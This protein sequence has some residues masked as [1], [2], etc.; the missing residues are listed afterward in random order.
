MTDNA[1]PQYTSDQVK[2]L[3]DLQ[4][5]RKKPNGF[6]RGRGIEGQFHMLRE[7]LDNGIDELTLKSTNAFLKIMLLR[8]LKK[9]KYQLI[10]SDTGRG[11]PTEK[12]KA[13]TTVIGTSAKHD[14]G[15]VYIST[16]GQFGIGLKVPAALSTRYRILSSNVS[17]DELGSITIKNGIV[18]SHVNVPGSYPHGLT[19]VF[20]PDPIFFES[21]KEFM[22][23]EYMVIVDFIRKI[24]IFN[25]KK[26]NH[27]T[28]HHHNNQQLQRECDPSSALQVIHD[29]LNN[30]S[31][32]IQ[33]FSD[34]YPD[35]N[36]YLFD[37]WKVTSPI[38][39]RLEESK[40]PKTEKDLLGFQVRC[41]FTSKPSSSVISGQYYVSV[42]NVCLP[43]TTRNSASIVFTSVLKN[44]LSPF[45]KE[46]EY[47]PFFMENYRLPSMLVAIDI[48]YNGAELIG[49]TKESFRDNTFSGQFTEELESILSRHP[50]DFW[51]TLMGFL[52]Q[53]IEESYLRFY[54]KPIKNTDNRKTLI[55]LNFPKYYKGAKKFG[56]DSELFI[57]EGG[58]AGGGIHQKR[59]DDFQAVL[60]TLGKPTN[61]ANA[62]TTGNLTAARE[63]LMKDKGYQDAM[64]ILNIYPNTTDMSKANF[65]KI[66]V[67]T[68][69]DPDGKHIS[70]CH[71]I[72]YYILNPR[73][74]ESGMLYLADPPL[75]SMTIGRSGNIFLRDEESFILRK[76]GIYR[77]LLNIKVRTANNVLVDTANDEK[78]FDETCRVILKVGEIYTQL[79]EQMKIPPL[80][81]EKITQYLDCMIP[82]F[83]PFD[84]CDRFNRDTASTDTY[85]NMQYDDIVQAII[86]SIGDVDH[87]IGIHD[88]ALNIRL[89][90]LPIIKEFRAD[91]LLFS[92]ETKQ[93]GSVY[94]RKPRVMSLVGAYMH[95]KTCDGVF[96]VTR[97]KGLGEM[98]TSD[99]FDAI[100]N[101]ATRSIIP[102]T[103]IGSIQ[104]M[105]DVMGPDS[106][107]RKKLLLDNGALSSM[108]RR[109]IMKSR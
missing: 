99:L 43:D 40:T 38:V 35:K 98:D 51:V 27:K 21:V 97:H 80:I 26:T 66:I 74:I 47:V 107:E 9:K 10:V 62:I 82:E 105:I 30:S 70:A 15:G 58:S 31:R 17:K 19:V 5:I 56:P 64:R 75:Y 36:A 95:L 65:G 8:D 1:L 42:N 46:K 54:N 23:S 102:I 28:N 87:A 84:L 6:I 4:L 73:I 29:T 63:L 109:N 91:E 13:A 12:L 61:A 24:N 89:R 78:L 85:I 96:T 67:S 94:Y 45:V 50:E 49:I 59:F 7:V 104:R 108:F 11:I 41:Y 69:A 44:I 79:S 22:E 106:E 14:T 90:L 39:F 83:K 37:V 77:Y 2:T 103:D 33:Y 57:V 60:Y 93:E 55:E 71:I 88:L 52:A 86:V 20:E 72:N 68:D 34:S 18:E 3:A 92:I 76:I 100:V 53:D 81:L 25:D 32:Q 101:P 16:G 48:R